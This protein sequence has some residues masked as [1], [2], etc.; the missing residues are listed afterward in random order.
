MK[1]EILMV[2]LLG[3]GAATAETR[4]TDAQ[5]DAILTG[6][7]VYLATP[8]GTAPVHYGADGR[9][10]A[11]LPNGTT[12]V[13]T[14]RIAGDGYCVDWENGP[15]NSCTHVIKRAGAIGLSDAATAEPRGSIDRIVPGNPEG[16]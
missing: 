4:M 7:T 9:S 13:G 3:A 12:L 16:L 14:W 2:T 1:K 8:S 5:V 10:A 6:I 15:R 11:A